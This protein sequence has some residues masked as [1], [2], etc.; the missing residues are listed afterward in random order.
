ME[1]SCQWAATSIHTL[2]FTIQ[3]IPQGPSQGCV[4]GWQ[5][6]KKGQSILMPS[7]KMERGIVF[8]DNW[9]IKQGMKIWC[10]WQQ[11]RGKK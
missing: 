5:K 4:A 1:G 9:V 8:L 10:Q 6:K 11:S 7:S 2:D 3:Y